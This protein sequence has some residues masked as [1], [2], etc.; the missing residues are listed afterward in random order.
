MALQ[1]LN[2]PYGLLRSSCAG[3]KAL[4]TIHRAVVTAVRYM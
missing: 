4:R 3:P 2:C 1:S